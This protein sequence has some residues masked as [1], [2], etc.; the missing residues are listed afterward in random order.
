M[1]VGFGV[2]ASDMQTIKEFISGLTSTEIKN[3]I[4]KIKSIPKATMIDDGAI[5]LLKKIETNFK[6]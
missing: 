5:Q 1:G 3:R 2:D 6:N 4:N